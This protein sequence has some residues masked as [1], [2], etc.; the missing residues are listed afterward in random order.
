M[1]KVR[2]PHSHCGTTCTLTPTCAVL[3]A[4]TVY[5]TGLMSS[6][7]VQLP[8]QFSFSYR[9]SSI[10]TIVMLMPSFFSKSS[11]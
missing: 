2:A 1:S 9:H 10:P 6:E 8:S 3:L 7:L 4:L 11:L 5:G